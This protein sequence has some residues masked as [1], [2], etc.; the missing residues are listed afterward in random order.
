MLNS[1]W[2][3]SAVIAAALLITASAGFAAYFTWSV[4][5][6][7]W[8]PLIVFAVCFALGLELAKP[9]AVH[10]IGGALRSWHFG[11]VAVLSLFVVVAVAYSLTASLQLMA[12]T[13]SDGVSERVGTSQ[14]ASD[15]RKALEGLRL[16]LAATHQA[17]SPAEVQPLIDAKLV[18]PKLLR[19]AAPLE[20]P[21]LRAI[22]GE[23]ATL[24][25]EAARSDRRAVL[26]V[27]IAELEATASAQGTS[28]SERV[29]DPS[30]VALA[31][32]FRALGV[33]VEAQR[34]GD[35]LVLVGVIALEVGAL[36]SV[37][38]V[39]AAAGEPARKCVQIVDPP[40]STAQVQRAAATELTTEQPAAAPAPHVLSI[41]D[42]PAER[43]VQLVR[44]RGGR[45]FGSQR[46]I[47]KALGVSVG[48]V[49]AALEKLSTGGRV[50]R[51][52]TAK[53]TQLELVA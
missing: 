8:W 24:R 13:R 47:A 28:T 20:D 10:A 1:I 34:L 6:H 16:E 32:Y 41:P 3:V 29:A 40:R 45:L 50:A 38:L 46:E 48:S 4:N 42:D 52:S 19:C 5:R 22:C 21:K 14:A 9:L 27:R 53:G 35:W 51:T 2:K 37:V 43:I 39:Q 31:T 30:A 26:G 18:N 7:E 12:R 15:A 33:Q 44:D 36:F 49:N 25:A 23:V 17:R 11:R